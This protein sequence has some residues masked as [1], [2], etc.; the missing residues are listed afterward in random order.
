MSSTLTEILRV[1]SEDDMDSERFAKHM[2]LR[3]PDSL[4]GL[5]SLDLTHHSTDVEEA[6]RAFHRRIHELDQ[7]TEIP[8]EHAA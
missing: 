3:H 4:G 8:H 6:W 2:S 1:A 5:K 7:G